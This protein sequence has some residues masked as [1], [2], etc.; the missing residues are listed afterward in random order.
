MSEAIRRMFANAEIGN[1][2]GMKL[3]NPNLD[4]TVEQA[5]DAIYSI[6]PRVN[7]LYLKKPLPM[8]Y[9]Y[10]TNH[11]KEAQKLL[12]IV[13]QHGDYR[14]PQSMGVEGINDTWDAI[15]RGVRTHSTRNMGIGDKARAKALGINTP[16]FI[17]SGR[18]GRGNLVL[19]MTPP[20]PSKNPWVEGGVTSRIAAGSTLP[21]RERF[22]IVDIDDPTN[23]E[24]WTKFENWSPEF[25]RA[26][27]YKAMPGEIQIGMPFKV[28]NEIGVSPYQ[29]KVQVV[30]S[31][32]IILPSGT[33][34]ASN[35]AVEGKLKIISGGQTGAD[36]GALIAA[37]ELGIPLEG[38]L[39][40]VGA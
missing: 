18:E 13:G 6:N 26:Y 37:R 24:K 20:V 25:A 12:S 4:M 34:I 32:P 39:R 15:V 14:H 7:D 8:F 33:R 5:L 31:Q 21:E 36:Y 16:M 19:A 27:F 23:F 38:W 30:Q 10:S 11:P 3:A 22:N 29:P 2:L 28:V 35:P 17:G 9:P 40:W 1:R